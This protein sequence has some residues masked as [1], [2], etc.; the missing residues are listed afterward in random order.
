MN[1]PILI[2][3]KNKRWL[4]KHKKRAP[5]ICLDCGKMEIPMTNWE[6]KKTCA[7]CYFKTL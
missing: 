6:G 5:I 2:Y 7:K 4:R 1:A 3:K